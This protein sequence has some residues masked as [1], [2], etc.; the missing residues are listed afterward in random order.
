MIISAVRIT[1]ENNVMVS[2][3]KEATLGREDD[4]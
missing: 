2:E 4:I 1:Q 3:D